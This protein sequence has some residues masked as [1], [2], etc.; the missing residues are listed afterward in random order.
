[1]NFIDFIILVL[2]LGTL[3][4]IAYFNFIKKDKDVCSKCP[5]KR[6]NCNCGKNSLNRKN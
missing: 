4:T 2:V 3:C 5:Y 1:M 6:E